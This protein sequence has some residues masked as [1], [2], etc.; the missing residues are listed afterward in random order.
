MISP[1]TGARGG[2]YG[3]QVDNTNTRALQDHDS[4]RASTPVYGVEH[5]APRTNLET[6]NSSLRFYYWHS[7]WSYVH[8]PILLKGVAKLAS[9]IKLPL[10]EKAVLT[11]G[12][13]LPLYSSKRCPPPESSYRSIS[14][15]RLSANRRRA[16]WTDNSSALCQTSIRWPDWLSKEF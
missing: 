9:P 7:C 6:E 10:Q 11:V 16:V 14:K 15:G 2:P 5:P 12:R 13:G 4:G 1:E 3:S 8:T